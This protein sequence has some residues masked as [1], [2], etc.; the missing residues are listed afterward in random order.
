MKREKWIDIG[1]SIAIFGVILDHVAPVLGEN[2]F[3]YPII[4]I[5]FYSVTL[6]IILAGVTSYISYENS[7]ELNFSFKFLLN[8]A[9][10][11]IISYIIATFILCIYRESYFYFESI[12]NNLIYFNAAIH[13]YYV[14]LYLQ[15]LCIS[16]ILYKIIKALNS[17]QHP[18]LSHILFFI[19]IAVLSVILTKY[20]N[21]LNIY[22]GGGKLLGGTFLT[23]Y[24]IGMLFTSKTL[25]KIRK[26][27]WIKSLIFFILSILFICS[28]IKMN[29]M[30]LDFDDFF[31]KTINPSNL[32]ISIYGLLIF[33]FIFYFFTTFELIKKFSKFLTI[34]A[35]FGKNSLYIF[36]YHLLTKD[37]L[38][39]FVEVLNFNPKQEFLFYISSLLTLP[40]IFCKLFIKVKDKFLNRVW[41]KKYLKERL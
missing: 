20:T 27:E 17:S 3:R 33:F 12:L 39:P 38:F 11:L 2:K 36:L 30:V 1:K 24:Y 14:F 5:S 15:L 34:L 40:V 28:V 13:L 31:K 4:L 21:I 23:L 10:S 25:Y 9:R 35:W 41:D 26:K 8:K 18:L 6:F 19:I 29:E 32:T 22:G 7:N 16:P 37:I